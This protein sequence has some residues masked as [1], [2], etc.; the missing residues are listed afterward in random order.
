MDQ[1]IRTIKISIITATYNSGETIRDTIESVLNQ[2]YPNIEHIIVDGAS[3]D[4]TLSIVQSYGDKIAKV[5]SEPDKGIYDAM[6]KG[7][8]MATGDIVGILNSDDF[9]DAPNVLS[10]IAS[11]FKNNPKL[12]GVYSNLFYVEQ[13]NPSKIVRHWVSKPFKQ[14]S[15]FYGWHPPHPTL[16]LKKEVYEKYGCF[17]LDFPLAADFELM[18]RF[19]EKYKINTKYID[20]TTI[21]MRLGG[22]TSKN[23]ENVRKQN[24]ECLK[25]FKTNGFKAP[26]LYPAYRLFPKLLQYFKR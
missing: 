18:L 7:I 14:K 21:R 20:F 8:R 12:D 26:I 2:D 10:L 11:E 9:F 6:N 17:N 15:F 25:A 24:V 5:V 3:K 13:N 22:A 19:F 1:N 16:Y 4:N 23:W